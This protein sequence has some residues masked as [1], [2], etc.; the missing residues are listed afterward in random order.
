MI[1]HIVLFKLKD[2][3][4]DNRNA[5]IAKLRSLEGQVPTLRDIEVGENFTPQERAYDVGLITRF[6]SREGLAAYAVDPYHQQVLTY[7]KAVIIDSKVV[8]F[9]S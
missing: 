1:T 4:A 7:V 8:D 6:D 3:T 9:E 2:N 5:L